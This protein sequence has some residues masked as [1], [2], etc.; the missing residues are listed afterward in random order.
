M[1]TTITLDADDSAAVNQLVR[2]GLTRKP[3]SR[4]Y[5]HRTRDLGLEVDVTNIGEILDLL[6]S[7]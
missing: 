4:P 1:R 2:G 7:A 6:N 3:P 5:R